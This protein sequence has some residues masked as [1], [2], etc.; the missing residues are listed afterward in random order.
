MS[1]NKVVVLVCDDCSEETVFDTLSVR[2]A[3]ALAKIAGWAVRLP[4]TAK[5]P[6]LISK[7]VDLCD[8]CCKE[9]EP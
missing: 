8:F 9:R 5:T 7:H 1:T 4:A 6:S 3:R 2:R